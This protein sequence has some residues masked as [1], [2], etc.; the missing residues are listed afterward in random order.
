MEDTTKRQRQRGN[1][2]P[3]PKCHG[4]ALNDRGTY[5]GTRY[6]IR[7]CTC[8]T[9]GARFKHSTRYRLVKRIPL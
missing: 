5:R 3:C 2:I 1:P 4:D 8:I 9:C 6:Y 7:Y